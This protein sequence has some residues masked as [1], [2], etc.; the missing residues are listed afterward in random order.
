[1]ATARE[2]IGRGAPVARHE[3]RIDHESWAPTIGPGMVLGLL[4]TVGIVVSMFLSW[5][6]ADVM[7]SDV[8]F[9]FLFD[10]TTTSN[11]PSLL[12]ALI[13][14]AVVLAVGS[15]LPRASGARI[16][17][18]L[19]TLVVVTLFAV[20]VHYLVDRFPGANMWDA[21]DTGWYVAAIAGLVGLVSGFMPSGWT[22]RRATEAD[23]D[24]R[25]A[26]YDQRVDYR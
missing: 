26:T 23:V 17:G 8:P 10:S 1:M 14:L 11:S 22:R 15:L 21:L 25:D 16:I 20:Q 24:G 18:G 4:G 3:R 5:R 19:G 9:G 6:T 12:L 7:P 13:P 2:P